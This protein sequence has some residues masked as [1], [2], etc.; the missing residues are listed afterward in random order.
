MVRPAIPARFGGR[1]GC[2]FLLAC[3]LG[4][5]LLLGHQLVMA[6]PRHAMAMGADVSLHRPHAMDAWSALTAPVDA[7]DREHRGPLTG[8]EE[9]LTQLGALPLMLLL[10]ALVG[11]RGRPRRVLPTV[12]APHPWPRP[13]RCFHPPPLE[14]SRRRA[15][16]QVFLI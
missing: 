10:L 9:C 7:S 12:A 11:L 1:L 15:L 4:L 8:W 5:A 2:P 16:L 14:P 3:L 13:A 6:T